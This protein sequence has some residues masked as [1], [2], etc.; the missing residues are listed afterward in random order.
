[1]ILSVF[2]GIIKENIMNIMNK[3]IIIELRE[4]LLDGGWKGSVDDLTAIIA[5]IEKHEAIKRFMFLAKS[6]YER[7]FK[8]MEKQ[9]EAFLQL[10]NDLFKNS[11]EYTYYNYYEAANCISFFEYE[12][13]NKAFI[14]YKFGHV[15]NDN[16]DP[17]RNRYHEERVVSD[18]IIISENKL[19]YKQ[20]D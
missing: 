16:Y 6:H 18:E 13:D 8:D 5:K 15:F 3:E 7:L 17:I 1:M 2:I 10:E 11:N 9:T 20:L 12:D 4:Y 14:E 19:F